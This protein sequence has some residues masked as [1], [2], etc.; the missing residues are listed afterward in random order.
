MA[1][2]VVVLCTAPAASD[3]AGRLGAH[4]LARTLVGDGLCACVN[5]V[6]GVRSYFRWQGRV[7]TADELL[8]VA[9]TT[10]ACAAALRARIA[11]LHPYEV[12]E[13]LELPVG[14]GLPAYLDWLAGASGTPP[15][16]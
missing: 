10:P 14:G 16:P 3:V 13:V 2:A 6:P 1:A 5:V 9:K 15:S 8:L 4:E 12:P 11:A 7:D